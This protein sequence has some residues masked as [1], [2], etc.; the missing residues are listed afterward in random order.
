[1][2]TP[3]QSFSAINDLIKKKNNLSQIMKDKIVVFLFFLSRS[4]D[5]GNL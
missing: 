3:L 1:M 5:L 2:G 4:F